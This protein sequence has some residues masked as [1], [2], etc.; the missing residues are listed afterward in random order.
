MAD[1]LPS[2]SQ[3]QPPFFKTTA[4]PS[5]KILGVSLF[6]FP[7]EGLDLSIP[8]GDKGLFFQFFKIKGHLLF[9]RPIGGVGAAR[10]GGGTAILAPEGGQVIPLI[11]L[12]IL[13]RQELGRS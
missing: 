8:A 2:L 10:Q 12:P 9:G 7:L 6:P 1:R 13:F 4:R 5:R 3:K 11:A